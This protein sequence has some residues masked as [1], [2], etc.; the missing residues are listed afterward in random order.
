VARVARHLSECKIPEAS[1]DFVVAVKEG[2][3]HRLGLRNKFACKIPWLFPR[4]QAAMLIS[5]RANWRG[6]YPELSQ[7]GQWRGISSGSELARNL[8]LSCLT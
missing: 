3:R 7:S 5:G 6:I 1:V 2:D 4:S 8:F